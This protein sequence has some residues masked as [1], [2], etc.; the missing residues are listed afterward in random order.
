[1]PHCPLAGPTA[2]AMERIERNPLVRTAVGIPILLRVMR[3]IAS[4]SMWPSDC[5]AQPLC[6]RLG[7]LT[8]S[9]IPS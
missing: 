6:K 2:A 7:I 9:R 1:M 3:C 5:L 8:N 4:P